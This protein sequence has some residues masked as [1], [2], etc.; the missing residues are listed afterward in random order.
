MVAVEMRTRYANALGNCAPGKVIA[1]P[2]DEAARLVKRGF[3]ARA[4]PR[5]KI[6]VKLRD[7]AGLVELAEE[8]EDDEF[9]VE[10][11]AGVAERA[12]GRGRGRP[13]KV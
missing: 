11:A 12:A 8:L 2:D 5:R 13:K 3:A 6:D 4:N 10:T 7:V 1:L 9:E